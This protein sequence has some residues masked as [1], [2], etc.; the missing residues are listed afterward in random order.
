[1]TD[2]SKRPGVEEW[3]VKAALEHVVEN[4]YAKVAHANPV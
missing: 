4:L 2:W 3:Q 1:M